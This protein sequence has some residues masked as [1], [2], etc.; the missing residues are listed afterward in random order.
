MKN[1]GIKDIIAFTSKVLEHD[2]PQPRTDFFEFEDLK[3]ALS[4]GATVDD[5]RYDEGVTFA[6]AMLIFGKT[7][8]SKAEINKSPPRLSIS[9]SIEAFN[10]GPLSI[11]GHSGQDLSLALEF[12]KDLQRILFDGQVR[13]WELTV[14][15]TLKAE[16]NPLNLIINADLDF[17]DIFKFHIEATID[18]EIHNLKE[19]GKCDFTFEATLEQ[20]IIEYIMAHANSY[21]LVAKKAA[22]EKIGSAEAQLKLAQKNFDDLISQKQAELNAAKALWDKQNAATVATANVRKENV[23]HSEALMRQAVADAKRK[24]DD[25][26]AKLEA[27]LNSMKATADAEIKKAKTALE[28][29]KTKIDADVDAKVKVL[30]QAQASLSHNFGS[31]DTALKNAENRVNDAQRKFEARVW[32]ISDET[33][34]STTKEVYLCT[35][36]QECPGCFHMLSRIGRTPTSHP[37][38]WQTRVFR[39]LRPILLPVHGFPS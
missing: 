11:T 13:L 37:S 6:A 18:G 3:L 35:R 12:S 15:V 19:I 16:L 23:A 39:H 4:T 10:V 30:Q 34:G 9:G 8:K 24:F 7:V 14:G 25:A 21:I 17:S 28:V 27:R 36:L 2:L 33:P 32:V 31:A 20:H 26:I 1:L 22:D 38:R 5:V 29:E